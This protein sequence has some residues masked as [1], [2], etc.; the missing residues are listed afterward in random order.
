MNLLGNSLPNR[1]NVGILVYY[2]GV[3]GVVLNA[4]D[5]PALES[6]ALV[7]NKCAILKNEAVTGEEHIAGLC[8]LAATLKLI[9][10]DIH[11]ILVAY[12]NDL[13]ELIG[14]ELNKIAISLYLGN[15][16]DPAA[17]VNEADS[18]ALMLLVCGSGKADGKLA[19]GSN[20]VLCVGVG[21]GCRK[22]IPRI[23]GG[24]VTEFNLYLIDKRIRQSLLVA[25]RNAEYGI[26]MN[27]AISTEVKSNTALIVG[28]LINILKAGSKRSDGI[29]VTA[30][31]NVE[32]YVSL[33]VAVGTLYEYYAVSTLVLNAVKTAVAGSKVNT[34][35]LA[36]AGYGH[37]LSESVAASLTLPFLNL[38]GVDSVTLGARGNLSIIL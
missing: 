16:T 27:D 6:E 28:K 9:G 19:V 24:V 4:V 30:F 35:V 5:L 20:R 12:Y 14:S 10:K 21:V 38:Y 18:D 37:P 8:A 1:V 22:V 32:H 29:T 31:A 17:F 25:Y 11:R 2:N 33:K 13:T 26:G 34:G 36:K 15:L 7:G 3:T 23:V